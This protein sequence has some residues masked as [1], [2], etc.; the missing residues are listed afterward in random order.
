[1]LESRIYGW[2]DGR[3]VHV[4]TV[5]EEGRV[6]ESATGCSAIGGRTGGGHI[7][8]AEISKRADE[9]LCDSKGA[10]EVSQMVETGL[11]NPVMDRPYPV[12]LDNES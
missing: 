2:Q 1:V 8:I 6:K 9:A 7:T 4:N 5:Y 12:A 3:R 11:R 10:I